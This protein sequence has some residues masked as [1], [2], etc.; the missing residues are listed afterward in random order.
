MSVQ[1]LTF[2]DIQAAVDGLSGKNWLPVVEA[3]NDNNLDGTMLAK[4]MTSPEAIANF[5]KE[6]CE[7]QVKP[8]IANALHQRI[9]KAAI[10]KG[11]AGEGSTTKKEP[12]PVRHKAVAT[13]YGVTTERQNYST[14]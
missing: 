2:K 13:V 1:S 11:S 4:Y 5:F 10:A 3:I 8:L 9:F 7:C 14:R 6:N 12:A